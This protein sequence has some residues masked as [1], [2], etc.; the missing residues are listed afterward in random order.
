MVE[1]FEK[2]DPPLTRGVQEGGMES[3]RDEGRRSCLQVCD[4]G[5][6][7]SRVAGFQPCRYSVLNGKER[8]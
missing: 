2:R 3:G 6:V 8:K 7:V 1:S 4:A 5:G